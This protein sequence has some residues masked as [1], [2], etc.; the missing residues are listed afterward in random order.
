MRTHNGYE[1]V[2]VG[3][4]P[5]KKLEKAI[6]TG[7]LTLSASDL[8]GNRHLLLHPSNAKLIKQAQAKNKGLTGMPIS[9]GEIMNDLE[10]HDSMGGS[11]HGGSLWSWLR[12]AAKSVGKFFKDNWQHIKPVLTPIADTAIPAIAGYFGQPALAGPVRSAVKSITGVGVGSKE[13]RLANLAKARQ[14]KQDK[15]KNTGGSFLIQ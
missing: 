3:D 5:Q 11:L 10:W 14:A 8:K 9:G 13:K 12:G 7:K 15:K 6:K 2:K 1:K 4:I